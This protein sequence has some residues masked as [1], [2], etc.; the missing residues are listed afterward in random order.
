ML[1]KCTLAC[2]RKSTLLLA[3]LLTSLSLSAQVETDRSL[4][5][6]QQDLIVDSLTTR[7]EEG[8]FTGNGLLGNM[9]YMK[10][11]QTLRIEIGRTDVTEHQ[12]YPLIPAVYSK[13]RLPIGYFELK[14][15]GRII[16]NSARLDLWNAE[17]RGE[18]VTEKGTIHWRTLT[19]S[20]QNAI[21]FET[22][23]SGSERDYLW[24]WHPET[25]LSARS[26]RDGIKN[27]PKAYQANPP[28]VLEK[29]GTIEIC[30]QPLVAGGD[31]TTVWE[32]QTTDKRKV[33]YIS[34]GYSSGESSQQPAVRLLNT[35]SE[36]PLSTLVEAH[37]KWWHQYY[38]QTSVELPDAALEQFY[39]LQQYKLASATRA[40]KPA[41]DLMGPWIRETPWPN[42]W[43]NLNL[44]LTYSPLYTANRLS[45][46]ESLLKLIDRNA[47]N[48]AENVPLEYRDDAIAMGRLAGPDL[49][50]DIRVYPERDQQATELDLEL[51][52]LT[53]CLYYYW[54]HYRY[55]MDD[56]IKSN[57]L[58]LLKKSINYYLHVMRKEVD[59]KWHLPYTCSPEYPNGITRD[60]NYDLSLFRWGCETLLKLTPMDIQ[61]TIWKDVLSNLVDYPTDS[62]GLKIGKDVAFSESHRHYSH[63]LMIYPL[64]LLNWEQPESRALIE[65]S[66]LHWHSFPT[67]LQGY[68]FTGGASIYATM[69]NGDKA[70]DYLKILLTRF[71]KPNTM[72]LE[73]GPVI[74]TPLAAVTS[75]QEMLLQSWGD[76]IRIFPAMPQD[77]KTVSFENLRAEGAFL[78]SASRQ[79]G[80]TKWVRI[81]SL[82]GAP[83]VVKPGFPSNPKVKGKSAVTDMGDGV[84]A[85]D[86]KQGEEITLYW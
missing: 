38:T 37:R 47:S 31:Y 69:G 22:N 42:Y 76:K 29:E 14:P 33:I 59:G 43:L 78:I 74:E 6:A 61:A 71:I 83:C 34:V 52:N 7:W 80:Q 50:S 53:W 63:L 41:I 75:L 13:A 3:L 64:H 2:V 35:L 72:Y 16:K 21:V 56:K 51:G 28:V 40:D 8:L 77:W 30:R 36:Q 12:D 85:L 60:C 39:W 57:L 73:S 17:V 15:Q 58:P 48:L 54:Q 24:Q 32:V 82:A 23:S 1:A 45:L 68:S 46:A 10:D 62:N 49:R 65:K 4:F 18:L 67:A 44:Q 11:S 66:L 86:I 70:R 79:D 26:V 9:V 20:E 19:L 81:K 27:V 55:T 84:Y 5:F 25:A